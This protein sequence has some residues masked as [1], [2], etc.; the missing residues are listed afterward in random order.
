MIYSQ[1]KEGKERMVSVSQELAWDITSWNEDADLSEVNIRQNFFD[2]FLHQN[3]ALPA[4]ILC[5]RDQKVQLLKE[6]G[7]PPDYETHFHKIDVGFG[8]M[9]LKVL[10][11]NT[12]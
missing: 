6:F 8:P 3:L 5:R 1:E 11:M 12:W 9:T 4:S 10:P 7:I 2:T